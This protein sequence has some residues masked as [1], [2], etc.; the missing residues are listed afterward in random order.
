MSSSDQSKRLANLV[1]NEITRAH[2]EP[3]M[4]VG[5]EQ[6][7]LGAIIS[8]NL[9]LEKVEDFLEPV[10]FSSKINSIIFQAL[11]KLISND[12]LADLNTLKVYLENNEEFLANGG[13]SYLLKICENSISIINSKQYGELILDLSIRRKLIDLGTDLINDSYIKIND[14]SSSELIENTEQNLFN[15]SNSKETSE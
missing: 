5:A 1:S 9:A 2:R 12:Q 10:H 8:N 14:G 3:P 7:L 13:F 15:L 11:K 6:A 4:N